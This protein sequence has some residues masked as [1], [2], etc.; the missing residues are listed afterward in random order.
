MKCF[1]PIKNC[2][3]ISIFRDVAKYSSPPM[4]NSSRDDVDHGA[5]SRETFFAH[6]LPRMS[7]Y[8]EVF[9]NQT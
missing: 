1:I 7:Y 5:T 6:F 3:Q 9:P 4:R 2:L 8:I